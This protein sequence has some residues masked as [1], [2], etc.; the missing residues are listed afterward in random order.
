MTRLYHSVAGVEISTQSPAVMA[1]TEVPH[2]YH[3][4]AF[5][6]KELHVFNV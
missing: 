1:A 3:C 2:C 6:F 5:D 4:H